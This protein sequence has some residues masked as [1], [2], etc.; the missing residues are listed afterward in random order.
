MAGAW[1]VGRGAKT[2]KEPFTPDTPRSL[3][4]CLSPL[5]SRPRG[6]RR[7]DLADGGAVRR[8]RPDRAQPRQREQEGRAFADL[9]LD[10][11]LAAV[12]LDDAL[13]DGQAGA[14]PLD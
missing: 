2:P 8:R 6:N 14:G 12:R 1:G 9:R 3:F 13:A 5:A 4:F 11:D 10:P 7:A